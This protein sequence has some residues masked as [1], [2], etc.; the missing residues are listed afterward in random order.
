VSRYE[1]RSARTIPSRIIATCFGLVSFAAALIVGVVADNAAVTILW[2]ALLLMIA[3]A[4]VGWVIGAISQ[5][6]VDDHIE[7][8]K[9]ANPIP[10][11]MS[12]DQAQGEEADRAVTADTA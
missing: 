5:R 12:A 2:R 11:N 1:Q 4:I 7:A 9:R 10:E 3:G 8:Y 6:T